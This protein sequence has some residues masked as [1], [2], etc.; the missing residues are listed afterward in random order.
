MTLNEWG[1]ACHTV[2][3]MSDN[4]IYIARETVAAMARR[5]MSEARDYQEQSETRARGCALRE[6][7]ERI[8]AR[9]M[10]VTRP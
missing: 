3:G 4:T 7:A 1:K 10:S 9:L 5:A 8:E 6:I 2:E